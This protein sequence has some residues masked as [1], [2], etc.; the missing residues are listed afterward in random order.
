[1][2]DQPFT[3]I[4]DFELQDIF[5]FIRPGIQIPSADTLRRDLNKSFTNAKDNFRKELQVI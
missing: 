2:K 5:T 3:A 4:E 1:V